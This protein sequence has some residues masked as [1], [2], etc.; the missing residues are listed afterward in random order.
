V[1][2]GDQQDRDMYDDLSAPTAS[3]SS[4]FAIVGIAAHEG[5]KAAVVDFGG[6]FLNAEMKTGVMAHMPLDKAMDDLLVRL[7]PSYRRY[8]DAKEC[9]IVPLNRALYGCVESAALWYENL[10]DAMKRGTH[11]TFACS[12]GPTS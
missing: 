1:A 11:T 9:I 10:R 3:T 12:T 2:G 5:R 7:H 6:A 8:Q 4:V